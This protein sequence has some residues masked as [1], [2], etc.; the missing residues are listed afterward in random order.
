MLTTELQQAGDAGAA[1]PQRGQEL[2]GSDPVPIDR[3]RDREPVWLTE[4][5]DPHAAGIVNMSGDHADRATGRP[6]HGSRP[7]AG[8]QVLEEEESDAI[9]GSPCG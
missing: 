2:P 5:F 7:E 3:G 9:V 4:D 6:R 8:G 1:A